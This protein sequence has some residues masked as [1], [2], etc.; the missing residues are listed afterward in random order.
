VTDRVARRWAVILA[1][2]S[3]LVAAPTALA[4]ECAP[5]PDTPVGYALTAVGADRVQPPATT[6]PIAVL[7]SG[8][9]QVPE[10][11]GRVQPGVNVVTGGQ[12]TTDTD[13]HG[14]AVATIAAGAAGAVRGVSP[15]SPV[16]PVKILD[17]RGESTAAEVVAGID[18]AVARGAR[19]INISAAG[20][21][22]P[23]T[24]D[25]RQVLTAIERAVSRR[26]VVVAPS[27]NEGKPGLDIPAI[28]PHVV[29][30][31]ASDESGVAAPFSNTGSGLDLVAP[32]SNITTAAPSFICST[33]YSLVSGTSF[34]APA[35][36]GA[37]AL[38]LAAQPSLDATQVTDA[39]RLRGTSPAWSPDMGFGTLDVPAV[40]AAPAPPPQPREV[41]DDVYWV[42][43]SKPQLTAGRRSASIAG[44]VAAHTDPADVYR[45]QLRAGDRFKAS[46]KA[47]G[48]KLVLGLWDAKTGS[49]DITGGRRAHRIA[50]G[51]KLASVRIRKSAAYYVSVSVK[52]TPPAG[53]AYA[54]S[55]SR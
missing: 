21:A 47:P 28:Y 11:D 53:A 25:D 20:P 37:A 45:L 1:L 9:G 50:A 2:A 34:S 3:V 27:G 22:G 55:L 35:V 38:L 39:L 15:T 46:V 6:P 29:A 49:F 4:T 16:I 31:G 12:N 14:T 8:I 54:L 43:G 48:A 19:V 7:D 30:V 44:R 18:A 32:G 24:A 52:S 42:K 13:G 41:D 17:A 23:M 33:G 5:R 36:A 10:L 40:L 51:T 26:V